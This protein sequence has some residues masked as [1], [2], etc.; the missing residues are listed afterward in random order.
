[1]TYISGISEYPTYIIGIN[2]NCLNFKSAIRITGRTFD[3]LKDLEASD[4]GFGIARRRI[5]RLIIDKIDEPLIDDG[6]LVYKTKIS[7]VLPKESFVAANTEIILEDSP[8]VLN[9]LDSYHKQIEQ[10]L[11]LRFVW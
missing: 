3:N 2:G 11:G 9:F 7:G 5:S 4:L 6:K 8:E 10:A 1:M